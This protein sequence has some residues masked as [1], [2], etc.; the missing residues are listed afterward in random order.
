MTPSLRALVLVASTA[1]VATP[2]FA[3][4]PATGT[5]E[6]TALGSSDLRHDWMDLHGPDA[7]GTITVRV[8]TSDLDLSTAAG[9]ATLNR[10]IK[11]ARSDLCRAV[12]DDPE[13]TGSQIGA[14]R[15]C[16]R[17][18]RVQ[19]PAQQASR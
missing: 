19:S 4:G 5:A 3:Q 11:H 8:R 7:S 9:Q 15:A 13:A 12:L 2:A 14:E 17:A 16:L 1:I 18:A 6:I 10:R